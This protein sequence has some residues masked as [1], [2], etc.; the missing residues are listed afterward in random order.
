MLNHSVMYT[1]TKVAHAGSSPAA[2]LHC[3][4]VAATKSFSQVELSSNLLLTRAKPAACYVVVCTWIYIAIF[5]RYVT[6]EVICLCRLHLPMNK[7]YHITLTKF[8]T[9]T[10][11]CLAISSHPA[12]IQLMS[13]CCF[14]MQAYCHCL[15]HTE[16]DI[17]P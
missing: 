16:S 17:R 10:K 11:S 9:L 2:P 14:G 7:L 3:P 4:V 12:K 15:G 6:K 13:C 5:V 8:Q 1:N